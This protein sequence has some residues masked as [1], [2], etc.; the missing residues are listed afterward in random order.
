MYIIS[1]QQCSI[2]ISGKQSV[3]VTST[4]HQQSNLYDRT[5]KT[6]LHNHINKTNLYN[7]SIKTNMYVYVFT[8]LQL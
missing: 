6:S 5:S 8:P 3:K 1:T 4:N 7:N 2:I